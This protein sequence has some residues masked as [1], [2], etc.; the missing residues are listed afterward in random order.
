MKQS[1]KKIPYHMALSVALATCFSS[2]THAA[3]LLTNGV[4]KVGLEATYP[5]FES[6]DSKKNIVGLDPD[7]AALIAKDLNAKP[8]LIDTKFT[9]LILGLG[10]KYD[11]VISGLY[12]TPERLKQADAIPYA[13]TGAS[14]IAL[15]N[16]STLPKTENDLCGVKVG[17]QQGTAWV[18][19]LKK[20]SESYCVKNGKAAIQVMEFPTASEVS[21]ALMSKNVNAQLEI[22]PAAKILVE[23]SRG[24]LVISSSRLVYPLPLGIY[25]TQGNTALVTAIKASLAKAKANGQYDVLIKKY[26]LEPIH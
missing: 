23:K 10:K 1:L 5:P 22:A 24:R 7:F 8:Q 26:N 12:V 2:V 18:S 15:K 4:F 17:L 19:S 6:Y 11:A 20:L 3:P 13:M 21:Q 25:V 14:I 16:S 9:S